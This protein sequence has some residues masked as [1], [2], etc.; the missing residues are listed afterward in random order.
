MRRRLAARLGQSVVV[1]FIVTTIAF[2]V[3]RSAPG[4][5]FSYDSGRITP[6]ER[7]EWRARFGYDRPLSVQ[8]GRY[9]WSVAHGNLGYSTFKSQPVSTAIGEA[10]PRT[11]A[12]AGLGL[13]TSF[14][15]GVVIGTMQA[16]RRGEWFDR[17]TSRVLLVLYSLP[18]FWGALI[19]LLVFA[20]W[21]PLFPA[22]G[23]VDPMHDYLPRGQAL[24][25][26]LRHFVLPLAS[27]VLLTTGGIA[28]FHRGAVLEV[29]P[30]DFLRTA[31]A[32]GV[33][34]SRVVW[35]HALRTALAPVI[36][37]LGVSFPAL[38]GGTVFVE[39][40]FAWPGLGLLAARA[41]G[42]RDYD[43]VTASVIVGALLVVVGNLVADALHAALDPRVRE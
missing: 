23:I 29:L 5:P 43:L 20:Y 34:E 33:P 36:V 18:D 31:R 21:W 39:Q 24:A 2:L 37:L 38:I 1:I 32:K 25:D 9:L 41:I 16:A 11:L 28:R 12:L 42:S 15:I 35:R 14:I 13:L 10:L 30:S 19:M 26:R 3:I 7:A 8:Y 22:G 17:I 6:A 40:V 27:I 4:D